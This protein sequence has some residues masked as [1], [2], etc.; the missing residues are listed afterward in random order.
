MENKINKDSDFNNSNK[1]SKN[2]S[3]KTKEDFIEKECKIINYDN[4]TKSLDI[5][6]DGYGIRM[7]KIEFS[8]NNDPIVKVRYKGEIG[9]PNFVIKV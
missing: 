2:R 7:K 1:I 4:H 9:K 8:Y 6:F 5:N 3:R